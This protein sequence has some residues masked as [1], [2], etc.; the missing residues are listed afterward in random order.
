MWLTLA[1]KA[2][3]YTFGT[4][5]VNMMA[6][7]FQVCSLLF[8]SQILTEIRWA[9]LLLSTIPDWILSWTCL[10][11]AWNRRLLRPPLVPL[12][13]SCKL[14]CRHRSWCCW[15]ECKETWTCSPLT[16]VSLCYISIRKLFRWLNRSRQWIVPLA[17]NRHYRIAWIRFHWRVHDHH[18]NS[19]QLYLAHHFTYVINLTSVAVAHTTLVPKELTILA[20]V[21]V[22]VT[23]GSVGFGFQ[24]A[25]CSKDPWTIVPGT[26][27]TEAHNQY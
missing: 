4:R 17:Y 23:P 6:A 1:T 15:L 11:Q 8:Y 3:Q 25:V 14:P 26:T 9:L 20:S 12:K 2:G 10:L 19:H 22:S 5:T 7:S 18:R 13:S 21:F 27:I 16:S 24:G